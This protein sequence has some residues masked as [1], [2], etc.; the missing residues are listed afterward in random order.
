MFQNDGTPVWAYT[1]VWRFV[2]GGV[3]LLTA[4]CV[5][6]RTAWPLTSVALVHQPLQPG[7]TGSGA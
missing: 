3:R 7:I 6:Y 1:L 2:R 4:P 5:A